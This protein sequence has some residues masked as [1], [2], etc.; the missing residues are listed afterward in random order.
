MDELAAA[1]LT[2]IPSKLVRPPRVKETPI[3]FE[4]KLIQTVEL[5]NPNPENAYTIV[6]GEVI[7]IHIADELIMENG[8]IDI[9]RLHPIARM[10]YQDYTEVTGDTVFTMERPD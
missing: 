1:G 7:G 10:G 5:P 8:Q 2:P 3:H 9:A 6:F 4:C